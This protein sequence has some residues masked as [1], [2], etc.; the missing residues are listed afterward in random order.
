MYCNECVINISIF[1]CQICSSIDIRTDIK[2]EPHYDLVRVKNL[3]DT[4]RRDFDIE[5]ITHKE[6]R[7][8]ELHQ[9][10]IFVNFRPSARLSTSILL[11]RITHSPFVHVRA[12]L[13]ISKTYLFK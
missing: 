6:W 10:C 8:T 4:V 12:G 2:T 5:T 1:F 3:P 9:G 11:F 13:N 7:I